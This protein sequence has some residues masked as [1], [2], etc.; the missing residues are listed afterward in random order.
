VEPDNDLAALQK[1]ANY[2]SVQ[3]SLRRIGIVSI[4]VGLANFLVSLTLPNGPYRSFIAFTAV[5][6]LAEGFWNL[7]VPSPEG[8]I[9]DGLIMLGVGACDLIVTVLLGRGMHGFLTMAAIGN[10]VRG[11]NLLKSW[12]RY[13]EILSARPN[14]EDLRGLDR[15]LRSLLRDD[16][17]R[18]GVLRFDVGQII[19]KG[20]LSTQAV[21]FIDNTQKAVL[22]AHPD[23]VRVVL[24]GKEFLGKKHKAILH[25]KTRQLTGLISAKSLDKLEI[26]QRAVRE[27]GVNA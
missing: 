13:R 27:M 6:M 25:I 8:I 1:I 11:I 10:L 7:R 12:P 22:V 20:L 26:W 19:W 15:L 18:P 23:E 4:M 5:I 17:D 3:A 16:E 14:R 21:I 24:R 2:W 9:L